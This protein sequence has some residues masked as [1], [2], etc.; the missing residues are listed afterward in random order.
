MDDLQTIEMRDILKIT[1]VDFVPD[2]DPLT[3]LVRG[4]DFNNVFEVYINEVVSPS[5]VVSTNKLLLAQVPD[6]EVTAPIRSIVAVSSRLTKTD[7]SKIFFRLG[8]SPRSVSGFE[9]LIQTFMKIMLQSTESDIFSPKVGGNLLQAVGKPIGNP[10]ATTLV[11]DFNLAV[12]Q[13]RSQLLSIQVKDP[14]MDASERLAFAKV[15]HVRFV[16]SE[17]ALLG[18]IYIGNQAGHASAVGLGL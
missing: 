11:S 3:L 2:S 17:L 16:P 12:S 7:R 18:R 4:M 6:S 8:D 10:S 14:S 1:G 13:A 9:R 15:L 5:V